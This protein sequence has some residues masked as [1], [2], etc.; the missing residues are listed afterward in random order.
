M[1]LPRV[2]EHAQISTQDALTSFLEVLELPCEMFAL[3][4]GVKGGILKRTWAYREV[5]DRF[6]RKILVS[7]TEWP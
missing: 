5:N 6:I 1:L 2:P 7:P 4:N 3:Q